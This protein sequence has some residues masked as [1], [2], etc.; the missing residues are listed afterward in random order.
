MVQSDQQWLP[1][2]Q[3]V[4]VKL[5]KIIFIR[6]LRMDGHCTHILFKK[7]N[8]QLI[9]YFF[10]L[11]N[12]LHINTYNMHIIMLANIQM[13]IYE[14]NLHDQG[15]CSLDKHTAFW[16]EFVQSAECRATPWHLVLEFKQSRN[17]Q[18]K[19]IYENKYQSA[20]ERKGNAIKASFWYFF[21]YI[22]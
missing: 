1:Q 16:F 19:N 9:K 8:S 13:K 5:I 2:V 4:C 6:N 12:N 3:V 7:I 14:N 11:N 10:S 21:T 18:T 22:V 20:L 15:F 17:A